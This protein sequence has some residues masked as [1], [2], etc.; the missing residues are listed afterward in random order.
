MIARLSTV[1]LDTSDPHGLARFYSELLDL[2]IT[3]VD[4]DWIDIGDGSARVSFQ[5]APNHIPPQ[6]PDPNYPQQLHLDI[7][8][9]DIDAAE[10]K[11]L[12]MGAQLLSSKESGFRVYS[13][14]A[15]HPFCLEHD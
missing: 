6:W 15:G 12:R 5:L 10:A 8:V 7:W 1:V 3:K 14:P 9:D 2:P 11:V 4:G 13:D